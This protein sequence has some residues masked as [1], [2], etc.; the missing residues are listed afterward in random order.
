MHTEF[1]G[2][3]LLVNAHLVPKGLENSFKVDLRETDVE[4]TTP[5]LEKIAK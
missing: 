3:K 5:T 1:W 2:G 4:R